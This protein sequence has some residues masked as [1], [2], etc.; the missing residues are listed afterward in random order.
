MTTQEITRKLRWTTGLSQRKFAKK[1]GI[2]CRTIENWEEGKNEPPEYVLNLL[3]RVVLADNM[4]KLM[5]EDENQTLRAHDSYLQAIVGAL[6]KGDGVYA[7][8]RRL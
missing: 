7:E 5:E 2:P 3:T 6:K 1:Y 4:V 8:L